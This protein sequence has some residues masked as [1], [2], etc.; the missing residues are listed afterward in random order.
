[1]WLFLKAGIINPMFEP[2]IVLDVKGSEP[3]MDD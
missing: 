3:W 1:M 2:G